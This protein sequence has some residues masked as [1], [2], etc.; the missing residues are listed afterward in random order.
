MLSRYT[1]LLHRRPILTKAV[2]GGV[3]MT[4]GDTV[5]QLVERR[6]AT[7]GSGG[8]DHQRTLRL[9]SFYSV[10]QMPFIHVW[11]GLL[12]RAFGPVTFF[13]NAPRFV[14]K[15]V[16]D[17]SVGLPTVMASFCVVQ[18]L[19][20]GKGTEGSRE[21]LSRDWRVMVLAGWQVWYPTNFVIFS[22]VP[23]HFRPLAINV[24]SLGWSM[25]MSSMN[26]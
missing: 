14:A 7:A 9:V 10:L 15:V 16:A 19:L 1:A 11:F 17:Q 25:Y 4:I 20:Q 2:T 23:L 24:I 13:T 8:L 18:P 3:I 21:K 6:R 26:G 12:E 5:Q 22:T